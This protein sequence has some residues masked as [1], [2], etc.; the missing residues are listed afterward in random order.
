MTTERGFW[1]DSHP[2]SHGVW[3]PSVCGC[4][5]ELDDLPNQHCPR[6]GVTL[7]SAGPRRSLTL[8]R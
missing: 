1:L 3:H 4:G 8:A 7:A 6:C 5:Q 2:T